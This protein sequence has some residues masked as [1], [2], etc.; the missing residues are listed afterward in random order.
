M[1]AV[2]VVL[3]VASV[4]LALAAVLAPILGRD[5]RVPAQLA[6]SAL[7]LWVSLAVCIALTGE[8]R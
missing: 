7:L 3:F 5:P 6:S 4:V 8:K 2:V 1:K